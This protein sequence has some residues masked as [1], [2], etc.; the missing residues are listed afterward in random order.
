MSTFTEL[1][2]YL[3]KMYKIL[4][5]EIEHFD[6]IYPELV[7]NIKLIYKATYKLLINSD[8]G[9]KGTFL[10]TKWKK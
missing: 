5:L 9:T 10:S 3:T 2:A 7:D 6:Y 8:L 4:I 1:Q